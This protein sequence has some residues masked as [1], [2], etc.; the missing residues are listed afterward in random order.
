MHEHSELDHWI[1]PLEKYCRSENYMYM[2]VYFT[3]Q[4]ISLLIQYV[5]EGGWRHLHGIR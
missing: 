1:Q 2:Y 4:N 3:C 5:S